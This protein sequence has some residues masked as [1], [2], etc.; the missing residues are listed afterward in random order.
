MSA[1]GTI[2]P[3]RWIRRA[4]STAAA[5][6]IDLT[7]P[8]VCSF[9]DVDLGD[10]PVDKRLCPACTMEIVGEPV[11]RC[12]RCAAAVAPTFIGNECPWCGERHFRFR[13]AVAIGRYFGPLRDAVLKLKHPHNEPLAAALADG[14]WRHA[15]D[16]LRTERIDLVVPI[17]MHWYR[18]IWRGWN[19]P[20]LIAGALADRL[21]AAAGVKV[22]DYPRLLRRLRNTKPQAGLS[23]TERVTNVHRAF[24]MRRGYRVEGATVLVVDDVMTTGATCSEAARTLLDAG[25]KRVVV[26]VLARAQGEA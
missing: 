17:P 15:G 21:S 10:A 25:A 20:E 26:A 3:F 24:G 7:F 4:F 9:C 5:G 12:S 19:S 22:R 23:Q 8:P 2:S 6:L 1:Q 13:R 16:V 14:L 18:R 11:Y